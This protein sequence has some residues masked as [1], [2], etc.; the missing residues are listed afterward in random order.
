MENIIQIK[1]N[2]RTIRKY[3]NWDFWVFIWIVDV[4]SFDLVTHMSK[5]GF[6]N[7]SKNCFDSQEYEHEEHKE[8]EEHNNQTSISI[9]Y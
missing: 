8:H 5:S 4:E 7:T 1:Q 3:I 9:C 2:S 6:N